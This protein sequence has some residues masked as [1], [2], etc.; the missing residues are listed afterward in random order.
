[1]AYVAVNKDGGEVIGDELERCKWG[2]HFWLV[3]SN[4]E[5][6]L[7]WCSLY[8]DPDEGRVNVAVDLPKGTIKKLIG[9]ELTWD[10]EPVWLN[11]EYLRY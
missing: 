6:G 8:D 4:K 3:V 5:D 2:K 1:M 7:F 11:G 10:D 9:R